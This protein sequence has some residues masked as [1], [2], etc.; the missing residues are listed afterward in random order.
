MSE[1]WVL[2]K[3]EKKNPTANPVA[4]ISN[5]S[6]STNSSVS[7]QD[8]YHPFISVDFCQSRKMTHPYQSRSFVILGHLN[9]C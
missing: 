1:C 5:T 2:Q 3:K 7:V 6:S 4:T 9:P 8:S